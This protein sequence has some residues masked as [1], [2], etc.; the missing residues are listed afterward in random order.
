MP[1]YLLCQRRRWEA[2]S[3]PALPG[4]VAV[5]AFAWLAS[6]LLSCTIC[7]E[8]Q[9]VECET[10]AGAPQ[11]STHIHRNI[12]LRAPICPQKRIHLFHVHTEL[13]ITGAEVPYED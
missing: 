1:A 3:S 10:S 2:R 6:K 13:T 4:K 7:P 11:P 12:C 5:A 8:Q 9:K